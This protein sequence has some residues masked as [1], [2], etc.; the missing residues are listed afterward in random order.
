MEVEGIGHD[1]IPTVLDRSVSLKVTNVTRHRNEMC[2]AKN[3]QPQDPNKIHLKSFANVD[4][5]IHLHKINLQIYIIYKCTV[6]PQT[7]VHSHSLPSCLEVRF[8]SNDQ[9]IK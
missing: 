8:R 9:V 5:F 6:Y 7:Y 3:K 2:D 1:F 4:I